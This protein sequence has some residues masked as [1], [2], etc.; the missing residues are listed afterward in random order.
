MQILFDANIGVQVPQVHCIL[1]QH[2]RKEHTFDANCFYVN[3]LVAVVR[4]CHSFASNNIIAADT[5]RG[6]HSFLSPSNTVP[7]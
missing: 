1:N 3:T 4:L 2:C 6:C 5:E 7:F